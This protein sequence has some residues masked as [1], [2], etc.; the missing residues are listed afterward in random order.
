MPRPQPNS[1]IKRK[2]SRKAPKPSTRKVVKKMDRIKALSDRVSPI[3]KTLLNGF[4]TAKTE[5]LLP[6]N[7]KDP[8]KGHEP[9]TTNL[10]QEHTNQLPPNIISSSHRLR[11]K[12]RHAD[13]GHRRKQMVKISGL[14][15]AR[16]NKRQ[17][18]KER[19]YK[20]NSSET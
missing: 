16:L 4:T 17:T 2:L 10:Y 15:T 1:G 6:L 19:T 3:T 13:H 8:D 18:Q 20:N 12:T 7:I 11:K 9:Q 5:L 14:R